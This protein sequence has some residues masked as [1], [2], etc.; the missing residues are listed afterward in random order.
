[1]KEVQ[2]ADVTGGYERFDALKKNLEGIFEKVRAMKKYKID[3]TYYENKFEEFKREFKLQD[4]FLQNSKMPFKEMQA[5]YEKFTL[6][7]CNKKLEA[8]TN[9]FEENVTPLYNVY[10]LFNNLE[11]LMDRHSDDIDEIIAKTRMLI[12]QING[13]STHNKIEITQLIEKAY[14]VIYKALK[15]EEIYNKHDILEFLQR[16][17]LSTNRE[18]LGRVIRSDINRQLQKGTLSRKDIDDELIE[19]IEEGLGYD[20]LSPEF[21]NQLSENS[22]T[23][24]HQVVY[25]RKEEAV[26]EFEDEVSMFNKDK[27][28]AIETYVERKHNVRNMKLGRV[29][30]RGKLLALL[31]TPVIASTAGYYIGKNMSDRIDEYAT[32]TRVVDLNKE[33]VVGEP[34]VVYDEKPTTYVA[35]ITIY[36]P[37]KKNPSGVGYI[38]NATAY[39]YMVPENIDEDYHVSIDDI[40]GNL[41]EKYKFNEPKDVLSPEDSITDTVVY[42]TETYQNKQDSRKS[43]KFIIPGAVIGGVLGIGALVALYFLQIVNLS[44]LMSEIEKLSNRIDRG[45]GDLDQSKETIEKLKARAKEI[46]ENK[47]KIEEKY[48]IQLEEVNVEVPEYRHMRQ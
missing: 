5:E 22:L 9:E 25:A 32:T 30:I 11:D 42:L 38:R 8:L 24:E 2:F 17:N 19:H 39:E 4:D 16:K 41:R 10:L 27:R 46:L 12:D 36:Q 14:K 1:M 29:G 7:E 13:I 33:V 23:D 28:W 15:Y 45:K 43:K 40:Q 21:L 44:E 26:D 3:I 6:T 35:T 48:G 20:Y 31:M 18:S 34:T 37:W 47:K